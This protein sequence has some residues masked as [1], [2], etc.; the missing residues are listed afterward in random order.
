MWN[1]LNV[2]PAAKSQHMGD[3]A[4]GIVGARG[5]GGRIIFDG[6]DIVIDRAGAVS[7][8]LHGLAGHNLIPLAK[9]RSVKVRPARRGARGYLQLHLTDE[10]RKRSGLAAAAA[11]VNSVLFDARDQ[12]AFDLLAEAIQA[13]MRERGKP[14]VVSAPQEADE[15]ARLAALQRIG[16]VTAGEYD[17]AANPNPTERSRPKR[18]RAVLRLEG[19]PS[20][21]DARPTTTTSAREAFISRWTGDGSEGG[22][23]QDPADP[24]RR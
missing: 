1:R 4:K 21:P 10:R 14:V 18:R 13:A 12:P 11:D 19:P 9:V 3:A 16:L 23:D 8:L 17:A 22:S 5:A 7:F 2:R 20:E 15:P 24:L 6:R